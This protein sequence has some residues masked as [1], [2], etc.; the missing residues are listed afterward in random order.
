MSRR[1]TWEI[2]QICHF[3]CQKSHFTD[4]LLPNATV[5]SWVYSQPSF[6]VLWRVSVVVTVLDL[7]STRN[8]R[9]CI[10]T[11]SNTILLLENL[12]KSNVFLFPELI[13]SKFGVQFVYR[14]LDYA[15]LSTE[16]ILEISKY[17]LSFSVKM[18]ASH[19]SL[20]GLFS[21]Q[22]YD[23]VKCL[24]VILLDLPPLPP[25]SKNVK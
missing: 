2:K 13:S 19:L 23:A 12:I 6:V 18:L 20:M 16:K 9:I 11:H 22:F 5:G 10:F 1:K 15:E 4:S 21:T 17:I 7:P 24:V 25:K 14:S 3:V 8:V